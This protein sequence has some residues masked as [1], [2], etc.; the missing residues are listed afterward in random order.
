MLAP[1]PGF[2]AMLRA[3]GAVSVNTGALLAVLPTV[4]TS[5]RA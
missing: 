1:E 3:A 4:N 2:S 5:E